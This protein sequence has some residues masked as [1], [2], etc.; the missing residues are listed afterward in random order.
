[1]LWSTYYYASIICQ[2]LN[3][4]WDKID[5]CFSGEDRGYSERALVI[6]DGIHYDPLVLE[7]GNGSVIQRVFPVTDERILVKATHLA[8][9]A[10]QVCMCVVLCVCVCVCVCTCVSDV[11]GRSF[12]VAWLHHNIICRIRYIHSKIK[13]KFSY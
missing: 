12:A 7:G 2:C 10:F 13:I 1:M 5:Y 3:S 6:Y 11:F 9:Q 4:T 8:R